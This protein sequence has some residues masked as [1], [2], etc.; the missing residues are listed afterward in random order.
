M[1]RRS[2]VHL[3]VVIERADFRNVFTACKR[4]TLSADGN[5]STGAKDAVTCKLCRRS[6]YFDPARYKGRW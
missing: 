2:V 1:P 5:N 3:T 6:Y 4:E